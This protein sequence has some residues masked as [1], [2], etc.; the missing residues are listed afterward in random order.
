MW[1]SYEA[2]ETAD[3]HM[4]DIQEMSGVDIRGKYPELALR[5][6]ASAIPFL[7]LVIRRNRVMDDA[8]DQ[9]WRREK[10]ELMRPLKV[11]MGMNEGEQGVDHGGVQQEFFRMVMAEAMNPDYGLFTVDS[12]TYSTWFRPGSLEPLYKFELLGLLVSLAVYNGLTLPVNFPL[13]LYMKLLDHKV[14]TTD[15]IRNGWPELAKGFDDLLAWEEGDVGDVFM[16]TYEFS[17]D[18]F[19]I[20]YN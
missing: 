3:R 20:V 8:L 10:R 4:S 7:L 6:E 18:A 5:M 12:R 13:A 15:H 9:L 2:A 16:R 11:I 19:G 1:K 14:K 17:Y